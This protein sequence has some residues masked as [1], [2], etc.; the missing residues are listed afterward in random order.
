MQQTVRTAL[1]EYE[2]HEAMGALPNYGGAWNVASRI[3]GLTAVVKDSPTGFA[4]HECR[5]FGR[6]SGDY[7]DL[8]DFY[9][10]ETSKQLFE[11]NKFMFGHAVD[12]AVLSNIHT[13]DSRKPHMYMGIKWT[14]L[15]P[16]AFARKRDNCFLEYL[17]YTHDLRGREV[18]MRV[19]MPLEISECPDLSTLL[20][21]KRIKTST[22]TIVRP[23]SDQPNTTQ[24]FMMSENDLAGYHASNRNYKRYMNIIKNMALFVDSKRISKRGVVSRSNWVPKESRRKCTICSRNFGATRRKHHCRLCGDVFCKR[25]TIVREI[26]RNLR[27][28]GKQ[29]TFKVVKRKFCKVCVTSMRESV[30][31]AM[32]P[33]RKAT[34][35]GHPDHHDIHLN[36]ESGRYVDFGEDGRRSRAS[37]RLS[38]ASSE[39]SESGSEWSETDSNCSATVSFCSSRFSDFTETSRSSWSTIR[40]DETLEGPSFVSALEMIDA[41]TAVLE[42]EP[43][44]HFSMMEVAEEIDT[45]DMVPASQL[46]SRRTLSPPIAPRQRREQYHRQTSNSRS[47][48]RRSKPAN[49]HNTTRNTSRSLDQCLVE[50][51]ELLRQLV[52]T[53]TSIRSV[54]TRQSNVSR[55]TTDG[56][57]QA[58]NASSTKKKQSRAPA[59]DDDFNPSASAVARAAESRRTRPKVTLFDGDML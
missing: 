13:V 35:R 29:R 40:S 39:W 55:A 2:R 1:V 26:P 32:V 14:C 24:Y 36:G 21:V 31:V 41:D 25:C 8:V 18:G 28:I 4:T 17:V 22:V 3:D 45:M 37:N 7:R 57:N 23:A 42:E 27:K 59:V 44:G 33:P 47:N 48:C 51:E 6:I 34:E 43:S 15:Q 52:M 10:A 53:A 50:Q 9:Y 56:E 20:K 58:T 38:V 19:S 16:S 11:W 12:A 54:S 49:M 46:I 30:S 5:I